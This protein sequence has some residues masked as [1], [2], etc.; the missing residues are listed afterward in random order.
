MNSPVRVGNT[1][2]GPERS[3]LSRMASDPKIRGWVA[4]AVVGTLIVLAGY[5]LVSQTIYNME[6]RGLTAGFDFLSSTAGFSIG[7]HLIDYQ[8]TDTFSR[9][10]LVGVVNTLFVSV[11]A[12]IFAT[13]FGFCLLYTSP[14]PR[15]S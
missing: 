1:T 8:P 3:R 9:V 12:I 7:F 2:H 4:Q 13:L 6:K 15:D 5:Y 14:S 10:F 11:I